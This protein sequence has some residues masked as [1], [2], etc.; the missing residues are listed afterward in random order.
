MSFIEKS[1]SSANKNKGVTKSF[2]FLFVLPYILGL[3]VDLS[4]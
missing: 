3:Y 4:S 1:I 2:V